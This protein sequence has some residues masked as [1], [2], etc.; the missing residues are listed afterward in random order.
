MT[1]AALRAAVEGGSFTGKSGGFRV[2]G[3]QVEQHGVWLSLTTTG[4]GGSDTDGT[5][6]LFARH[7]LD[8]PRSVPFACGYLAALRRL[9]ERQPQ[10]WA[11]GYLDVRMPLEVLEVGATTDAY[12]DQFLTHAW[13]GRLLPDRPQRPP[14]Y[15]RAPAAAHLAGRSGRDGPRGGCV[16]GR[17]CTPRGC[18]NSRS[19][20]RGTRLRA[21]GESTCA[22]G[23][24]Y[25]IPIRVC[26]ARHSAAVSTT[27]A[28]TVQTYMPRN[29]GTDTSIRSACESACEHYGCQQH[30]GPSALASPC[31]RR[32]G[33]GA[34]DIGPAVRGDAR[35]EG[36]GFSR[37]RARAAA[38]GSPS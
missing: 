33:G 12:R 37:S 3:L 7:R 23:P 14:A 35:D 10:V 5:V 17:V 6:F 8:D 34:D 31:V 1:E 19:P 22:V 24:E 29:P 27:F 28:R 32:K 16:R 18:A 11:V 9:L 36:P 13:L 4:S 30:P 26:Q 21:G 38:P 2:D 20:L 25:V 15:V